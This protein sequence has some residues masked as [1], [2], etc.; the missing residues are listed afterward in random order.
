MQNISNLLLI[1]DKGF[2]KINY[3]STGFDKHEISYIECKKE[4]LD[5]QNKYLPMYKNYLNSVENLNEKEISALTQALHKVFEKMEE[6]SNTSSENSNFSALLKNLL[7]NISIAKCQ[8][9]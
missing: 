9:S 5:F 2:E 1:F 7:I 4:I 3:L 6:F 8:L